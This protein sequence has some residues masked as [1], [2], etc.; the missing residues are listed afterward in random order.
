[1]PTYEDGISKAYL[2]AGFL[3]SRRAEYIR[4]NDRFLSLSLALAGVL[5]LPFG[6]WQIDTD[7]L[8]QLCQV[9]T[10]ELKLS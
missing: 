3:S 10:L 7:V 1:M 2:P 8:S 5:E 9:Y 4:Q 6:Q